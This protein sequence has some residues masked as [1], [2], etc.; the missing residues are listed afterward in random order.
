MNSWISGYIMSSSACRSQPDLLMPY[1]ES[2]AS[3]FAENCTHRLPRLRGSRII[4]SPNAL[5]HPY[6]HE[7]L[8]LFS[9]CRCRIMVRHSLFMVDSLPE[10]DYRMMV[11]RIPS[12]IFSIEYSESYGEAFRYLLL[13]VRALSSP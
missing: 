3:S 2:I 7:L 6:F 13:G 4:A 10:I 12:S 9:R 5:H 1:S 8:R 11:G